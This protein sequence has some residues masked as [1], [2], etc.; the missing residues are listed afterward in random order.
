MNM[1]SKIQIIHRLLTITS[2]TD[3][4]DAVQRRAP[5]AMPKVCRRVA[6]VAVPVL[7]RQLIKALVQLRLVITSRTD[8]S[9]SLLRFQ[10]LLLRPP[11]LLLPSSASGDSLNSRSPPSH[12]IRFAF[13]FPF[14]FSRLR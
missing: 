6:P 5:V 11:G 9:S 13:P 3:F 10:L 2:A 8:P 1:K 14:A 4:G 12:S 7:L